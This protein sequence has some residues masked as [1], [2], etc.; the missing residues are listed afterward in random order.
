[1]AEWQYQQRRFRSAT[2]HIDERRHETGLRRR[3]GHL[4]RER[5][6][7]GKNRKILQDEQWGLATRVLSAMPL[8][9]Q[10]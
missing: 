7:T 5:S 6:A 4:C 10:H 9:S 2:E 1:M 8:A 3:G